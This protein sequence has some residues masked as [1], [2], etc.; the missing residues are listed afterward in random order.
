M[1]SNPDATCLNCGSVN[2]LGSR[3][4]RVCGAPLEVSVF[5]PAGERVGNFVIQDVLGRGGFG[6]T[7]RAR[8]AQ[9]G[10]II[11]L[12][13][14]FPE[15]LATR[16]ADNAV[17]IPSSSF[18]EWEQLK[19]RFSLEAQLLQRIQHKA[20]TYFKALFEANDTLYLAMEFVQGE[21][22]EARLQSGKRLG[23]KE[24]RSLL[25]DVLG[26]LEEVHAA[27]LLHRD[28]KPAN[29]IM[30]PGGAELIDFGSGIYFEKNRTM[31]ISQRILTP[32]YAPLELY[33]SNVRLSPAS[34]LYSLAATVYEAV[35][36]VRPPS[37]LERVNGA[38]L[39]SLSALRPD[40]SASFA[41]AIDAALEIRVDARPQSV[42]AFRALLEVKAPKAPLAASVPKVRARQVPVSLQG[43]AQT[44]NSWSDSD[45]FY[46]AFPTLLMMTVVALVGVMITD[47]SEFWVRLAC[48]PIAGGVISL[49]VFPV[50]WLLVQ[51]VR[52]VFG[53]VLGFTVFRSKSMSLYR[54]SMLGAY[55][56]GVPFV[57]FHLFGDRS[58]FWKFFPILFSIGSVFSLFGL[59]FS[60]ALAKPRTPDSW[61]L[62]GFPIAVACL[63]FGWFF[64]PLFQPNSSSTPTNP[65]SPPV[66]SRPSSPSS[67]A[68]N[69]SVSS[70]PTSPTASSSAQPAPVA[71]PSSPVAV[72]KA[73]ADVAITGNKWV[74]K[75]HLGKPFAETMFEGTFLIPLDDESYAVAKALEPRLNAKALPC[76]DAANNIQK[77][78]NLDVSLR[79]DRAKAG[80][81]IWQFVPYQATLLALF[82]RWLSTEADIVLL[83]AKPIDGSVEFLQRVSYKG[84][85]NFILVSTAG[86]KPI[87]YQGAG[88]TTLL[89][90]VAA[91]INQQRAKKP[92]NIN[93]L[94]DLDALWNP[95]V[96]S[97]LPVA[98]TP[99]E[100][101]KRLQSGN[102]VLKPNGGFQAAALSANGRFAVIAFPNGE[103][104]VW[105]TISGKLLSRFFSSGRI[106]YLS[107]DSAGRF[108]A[109]ASTQTQGADI[110][111]TETKSWV[112]GQANPPVSDIDAGFVTEV[113]FSPDGRYLLLARTAGNDSKL[114]VLSVAAL[115]QGILTPVL[116]LEPDIGEIRAS[117]F[118]ADS[119]YLTVGGDKAQLR[120]YALQKLLGQAKRG[121]RIQDA[122]PLE[123][124]TK[125]VDDL[126]LV[127][128]GEMSVRN[129]AF[130]AD[131]RW[132]ASAYTY[133]GVYLWDVRANFKLVERF[134]GGHA[135]AF[136]PDS[137][138]LLFSGVSEY[139]SVKVLNLKRLKNDDVYLNDVDATI[140]ALS[141]NAKRQAIGISRGGFHILDTQRR[142]E[143]G[144]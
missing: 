48:A 64:N 75:Q 70:P 123:A 144:K 69:K 142:L 102:T 72:S 56:L 44:V 31:K 49:A 8:D 47:K 21:T 129:L 33:G 50:S 99:Q 89:E 35:S 90:R 19:T 126:A 78:T 65:S 104:G 117:A 93:S 13:E 24:A 131:G 40:I 2:P 38:T 136:S 87:D 140:F 42:A 103:V 41:K 59:M 94:E 137:Q 121:E 17:R 88:R 96:K 60:N 18:T 28:I 23:M 143:I 68:P 36:G 106:A 101:L 25:K 10:E 116:S 53:S 82:G 130:S 120:V 37:A 34:D 61:Q 29:I 55:S 30:Q 27:N 108:V 6:I 52:W 112:E 1:P 3:A 54:Q 125:T 105:D 118:N 73:F 57:A 5:L 80:E 107:I 114:E 141:F 92:V 20:S 135:V 16:A 122:L 91:V 22:L 85:E 84:R 79:K 63:I 128:N 66:S 51:L 113:Q 46:L 26:V 115:R 74:C 100:L 127:R 14:L 71:S 110:F 7:Y 134:Y 67:P 12:K 133:S 45:M 77:F 86:L 11:A 15:G 109:A 119:S 139:G 32:A 132:M 81:I 43:A 95:Q 83:T 76:L 98:V 138:Q 111:N 62:N 124:T 58:E 9:T 97:A 4:C 39:E